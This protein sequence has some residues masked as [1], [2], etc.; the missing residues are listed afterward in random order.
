MLIGTEKPELAQW[1]S[2]V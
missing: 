1:W 2:K